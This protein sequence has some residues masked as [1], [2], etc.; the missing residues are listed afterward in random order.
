MPVPDTWDV[1]SRASRGEIGP[2]DY[3]QIL[4]SNT[5]YRANYMPGMMGQ[6]ALSG[7]ASLLTIESTLARAASQNAGVN[8]ETSVSSLA[9]GANTAPVLQAINTWEA[10]RNSGAFIRR[11]RRN[12]ATPRSTGT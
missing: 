1:Q 9:N 5:F 3:A 2:T 4:R 7:D 10:A 8:F 12:C 11:S 6:Q